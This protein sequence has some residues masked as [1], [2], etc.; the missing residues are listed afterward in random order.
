MRADYDSEADALEIILRRVE[1]FDGEEHVE[2][3]T[4]HVGMVNGAPVN[5]ELLYPAD[6]LDLLA[7]AAE[8][9]DLDAEEL[10]ATAQAA[11]AAPDHL[12]EVSVGKSLAV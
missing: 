10:L 9:Y 3:G 2:E 6:H 11:L 5:V 1:R 4:C 12:V 7:I 8:R